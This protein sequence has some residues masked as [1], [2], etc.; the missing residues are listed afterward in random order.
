MYYMQ[1]LNTSAKNKSQK[2]KKETKKKLKSC[3]NLA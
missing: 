1:V 3:D 2:K